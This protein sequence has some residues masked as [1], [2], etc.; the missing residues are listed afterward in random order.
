MSLQVGSLV[1][2]N[3]N[4]IAPNDFPLVDWIGIV[5]AYR[6]K[7]GLEEH[8]EWFVQWSHTNQETIEYGYYLEVISAGG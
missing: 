2:I 6:G 8:D 4:Y 7:G 1:K 5:L 3:E